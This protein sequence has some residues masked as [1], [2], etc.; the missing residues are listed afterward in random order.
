M[1]TNSEHEGSSGSAPQNYLILI[2]NGALEFESFRLNDPIVTGAQLLTVSGV[3]NP[4]EHLVFQIQPSGLLEEIH[5]EESTALSANGGERFLVFRSDRSFRFQ[6]DDRAFDWGATHI[7][8]AT[9]KKLVARD[10]QEFDVWQD[11][12]GGADRV[13]GDSELAN[14][15]TQG[16]ERFATKR[17]LISLFVNG[18]PREVNRR[19]LSY[20]DVV[21]LAFPEAVPSEGIIYTVDYARG[22]HVNPEGTLASGQY[23]QVK[24][25]MKFYVTPTDKS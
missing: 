4:V 21:L 13:I 18:K 7:S 2:G 6:L 8:G 23:V 12:I 15:S 1:H 11:T 24:E 25:G 17:I 3:R 19:R 10:A 9:L 20:W 14:L 16:V 22:P 5:P